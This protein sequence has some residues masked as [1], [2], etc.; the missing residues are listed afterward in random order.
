[1]GLLRF[2]D[3]RTYWHILQAVSLDRYCR[4]SRALGRRRGHLSGCLWDNVAF[5]VFGLGVETLEQIFEIQLP[6]HF[7]VGVVGV[8]GIVSIQMRDSKLLDL[9]ARLNPLR[10]HTRHHL[11]R[12]LVHI[13]LVLRIV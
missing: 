6:V 9:F 8:V 11:S 12:I 7:P 4:A 1:M 2:G 5:D 13:Q 3:H 10:R